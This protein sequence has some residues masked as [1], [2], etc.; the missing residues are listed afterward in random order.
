M[1]AQNLMSCVH[2]E[3]FHHQDFSSFSEPYPIYS[4]SSTQSVSTVSQRALSITEICIIA[5]AG[6]C[7]VILLLVFTTFASILCFHQ[8]RKR[9]NSNKIQSGEVFFQTHLD[10][11]ALYMLNIKL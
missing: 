5:S 1:H 10:Y 4:I 11:S 8:R 6:V 3:T 2:K 9:M 7:G